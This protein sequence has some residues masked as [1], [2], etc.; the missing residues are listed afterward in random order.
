MRYAK[1]NNGA[2]TDI[3]EGVLITELETQYPESFFAPCESWETVG[4]RYIDGSFVSSPP[5][6]PPTLGQAKQQKLE[7]LHQWIMGIDQRA[8]G[9]YASS[10]RL[11]FRRKEDEARIYLTSGEP[12]DAPYLSVE[13]GAAGMELL[14][15]AQ[16]VVAKADGLR[17]LMALISG[18]RKLYEGQ[19]GVAASIAELEQ[20]S[21]GLQ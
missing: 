5:S 10:E 18:K 19:I 12:V 16:V 4:T 9:K 21:F 17:H 11:D 3:F 7:E 13:A 14:T 15:L 1:I 20:I 8:I 2:I 6:P